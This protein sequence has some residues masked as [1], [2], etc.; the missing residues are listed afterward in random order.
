LDLAQRLA[1]PGDWN[2]GYRL[3]YPFCSTGTAVQPKHPD[4]TGFAWASWLDRF[5]FMPGLMYVGGAGQDCPGETPT[6]ADD[7]NYLFR[8]VMTFD[9][10]SRQ[11]ADLSAD[12]LGGQS[13]SNND[14]P[15]HVWPDPQRKILIR[16]NTSGDLMVVDEFDTATK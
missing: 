1:S 15:W 4:Y 6:F 10:T 11:W 12:G 7:P 16:L 3:E 9:V 14:L 13:P 5:V 2:A 8:H